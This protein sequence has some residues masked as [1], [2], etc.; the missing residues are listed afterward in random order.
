[1]NALNLSIWRKPPLFLLSPLAKGYLAMAV[2]LLVWSGFALTVRTTSTSS[3]S[4]ADV[5]LIRFSVPLVLL[6]PWALSCLKEIKNIRLP[7][8]MFIVLGGAPFLFLASVGASSAP[9]AYVGTILT[10]TPVFFAALLSFILYRQRIS[11]LKFAALTLILIGV[12]TMV[13]GNTKSVSGS[14]LY[15]VGIL[16]I[17]GLVWASY[18]IGLKR[19]TLSPLAIAI[20]LSYT[21]FFITLAMVLC[22]ALETNLGH[23]S[24]SDALPFV[25]IQGV[26]VGVIATIGFSYA[27]NQLGSI[28]T[29]LLGALSPGLTALLAALL[30]NEALSLLMI[31]GIALCAI[32]VV[33]SNRAQ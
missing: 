16:L 28:R 13:L 11:P 32:G 22:E 3:L 10:G 1:M 29:L 30:L 15:G 8:V 27:V 9:A 19:T 26:G 18:T 4:I 31:C 5:M 2:V 24:L 17:A 23:V 25:L 14:L 20:V 12:A 33:L 6:T 7:D 21:S